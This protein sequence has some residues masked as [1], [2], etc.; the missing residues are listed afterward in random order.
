MKLNL[1]EQ[2]LLSP[3]APQGDG[4]V[5]SGGATGSA[6]EASPL[7]QL[8]PGSPDGKAENDAKAA[9]DPKAAEVAAAA[10]AAKVAEA[11]KKV[12]DDKAKADPPAGEKVKELTADEKKA[13]DE[14]AAKAKAEA[15]QKLTAEN[16]TALEKA[17]ADATTDEAKAAAKAALD[18]AV[19][20]DK[21]AT[22]A[23]AAAK[24]AADFDVGKIQMPDGVEVDSKLLA[25]VAPVFKELGLGQ[26]AGQKV[27]DQYIKI[28]QDEAAQHVE[29]VQGWFKQSS[30]DP[31][32]GGAKWATTQETAKAGLKKFIETHP[33]SEDINGLLVASGFG[34]HPAFIKLFNDYGKMTA[35][36][37][38]VTPQAKAGH[39]Q[40]TALEILYPNAPQG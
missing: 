17:L 13:A 7:G 18:K 1:W 26:V 6:P 37:N 39:Q 28:K 3:D 21:K 8:Y 5:A 4:E 12:A 31:E 35:D 20:D 19:E 22:E 11:A 2:I 10:E 33:G 36:D 9:A 23:E 16:K 27:V 38:P 29:V 15:P 14:A 24:V 34:N 32:I 30:E 25:E 40:K